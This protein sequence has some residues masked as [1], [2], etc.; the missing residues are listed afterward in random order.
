MVRRIGIACVVLMCAFACSQ[1]SFAQDQNQDDRGQQE[2]RQ[3]RRG[4]RVPG[5]M[6]FQNVVSLITRQNVQAE[7]QLSDEQKTKLATISQEFVDARN[8][9]FEEMRTA[10]QDGFAAVREKIREA[11]DAAEKKVLAEL[12]DEQKTRINQLFLQAQGAAMFQVDRVAEALSFTDEQKAKMNELREATGSKIQ[13]LL[14]EL[15]SGDSDRDE[16]VAKIQ[17]LTDELQQTIE[18]T[19]TEAQKTKLAALLGSKFDLRNNSDG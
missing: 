10:G 12:N 1:V 4:P 13:A 5:G 7:L 8:K 2:R 16:V 18:A 6:R 9:L 14:R 11:A 17:S 15:R 3:G 19:L